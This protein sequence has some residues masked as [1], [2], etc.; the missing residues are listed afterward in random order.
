MACNEW[1]KQYVQGK[2][3]VD[4]GRLWGTVNEKVSVAAKAGARETSMID[5]TMNHG[6]NFIREA[7]LLPVTEKKT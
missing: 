3:F 6:R 4:V 1:I 5:I 2:T 7:P